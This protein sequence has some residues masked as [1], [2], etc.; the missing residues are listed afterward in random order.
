[1]VGAFWGS[2]H[3]SCLKA[4]HRSGAEYIAWD[5]HFH[6]C[7]AT[8]AAVVYLYS[9][10]LHA[11]WKSITP[12]TEI[13]LK[14]HWCVQKTHCKA[15]LF[16]RS[17]FSPDRFLAHS[18]GY[19]LP[20]FPLFLPSR[21]SRKVKMSIL[22]SAGPTQSTASFRSPFASVAYVLHRRR[23]P[24]PPQTHIP[25]PSRLRSVLHFRGTASP[26]EFKSR[27]TSLASPH[28]VMYRTHMQTH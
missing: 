20:T 28:S 15:F 25:V 24:P 22:S 7:A 13:F 14:Q 5:S 11:L 16:A 10:A 6:V 9:A 23:P 2:R 4:S 21:E 19:S 18:C 8:V 27:S 12:L 17:F 26:R 1:M 3:Y